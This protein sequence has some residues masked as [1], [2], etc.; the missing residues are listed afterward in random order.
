MQLSTQGIAANIIT[1]WGAGILHARQLGR[2]NL[3]NL[4]AVLTALVARGMPLEQAL[5]KL[6]DLPQVPGRMEAFGG[7]TLPTVIVDY[8]HKPEA[9][10]QVLMTL[11]GC[12]NGK[13]WCVFGCGG[14]RDRAKR[15][16]MG[17]LAEQY[18]DYLIVTDDNPRREDP[19]QIVAEILQQMNS[20]HA[21]IV[22]HDRARAIAHAISCARPQDII[23]VAG[24]GH[25][26]YQII[27][28]QRI[29][30]SDA[31]TVQRLLAERQ[32]N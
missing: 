6:A 20:P 27:G 15:S 26:A 10:K 17:Q 16:I 2:F 21:V 31:L 11:R 7:G 13:L 14:N 30:F 28:E 24:K 19:K 32:K 3:S 18:A 23:L 9:L 5:A 25:E 12:C 29:L 1:P 4:L 8:A 22:E